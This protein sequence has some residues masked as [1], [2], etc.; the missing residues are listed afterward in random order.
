MAVRERYKS[1]AVRDVRGGKG[2]HATLLYTIDG[3]NSEINARLQLKAEAPAEYDTLPLQD[4]AT[5]QIGHGLWL[6]TV[7]YASREPR[8]EEHGRTTFDTTG[9][10]ELITVS[11]KVLATSD[12]A[13]DI[14]EGGEGGAINVSADGTVEGIQVVRPKLNFQR[15]HIF[16]GA[17]IT[18]EYVKMLATMTGTTNNATHFAFERGELLFLGASGSE[19]PDSTWEV[20]FGWAASPNKTN[21]RLGALTVPLKRGHEYLDVRYRAKVDGNSLIQVP[22][23]WYL[24]QVYEESNFAAFGIGGAS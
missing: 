7:T 17:A 21:I 5:E 18:D 3:T 22:Q 16:A 2:C 4:Y 11:L 24:H 14:Q 23:H 20:L 12:G 8:E 19:R 1:R 13:P 6:G 15:T 10:L 9:G